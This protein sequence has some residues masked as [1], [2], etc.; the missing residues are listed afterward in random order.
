M[1]RFRPSQA[2]KENAQ[3]NS[4]C[5]E[6]SG[7]LPACSVDE[8]LNSYKYAAGKRRVNTYYLPTLKPTVTARRRTRGPERFDVDLVPN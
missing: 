1:I 6:I 5:P 3:T 8:E 4:Y 7:K 2:E